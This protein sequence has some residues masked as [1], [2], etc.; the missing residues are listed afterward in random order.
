MVEEPLD[1]FQLGHAANWISPDNLDADEYLCP[2]GT[3]ARDQW[4]DIRGP[5]FFRDVFQNIEGGVG[6]WLY[7]RFR[8][9]LPKFSMNATPDCYNSQIASPGWFFFRHWAL[10]DPIQDNFLGIAQLSNRILIPPDGMTFQGTPKGEF[11]GYTYMALPMTDASDD[12]QP[13]GN[14]SMTLFVNS[15]NFKGP[16]AYYLPETWSRMSN[17]FNFP[18]IQGR[19]LDTRPISLG[20]AASIEIGNMPIITQSQSGDTYTKIPSLRFPVNGDKKTVLARDITYYSKAALFNRV[21]SW[22]KG[23]YPGFEGTFD[24]AGAVKPDLFVYPENFH[25]ESEE[26][27]FK[28]TMP[29]ATILPDNSI[30]LSWTPEAVD[31][32]GQFPQYFKDLGSQREVVEDEADVPQTLRDAPFAQRVPGAAYNAPLVGAWANPGPSAGPFSVVLNDDTRVTYYWYRFIDQP[33]FQ[34]YNYDSLQK[35]ELQGLVQAIHKNWTPN[36]TYMA[37]PTAGTLVEFDHALLVTPPNGMQVGYVPIVVR[38][39]QFIL[40]ITENFYFRIKSSNRGWC[41]ADGVGGDGLVRSCPGRGDVLVA[42]QRESDGSYRLISIRS[43]KHL[44]LDEAGDKLLSTRYQPDN[45]ATRFLLKRLRDGTYRITVKASGKHLHADESADM[46][47]STRYQP[48]DEYSHFF[49]TLD[50]PVF[51]Q[52]FETWKL[53]Q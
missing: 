17:D 49:L 44:H 52:G 23:A 36:E 18:Y 9:G 1:G 24:P 20:G 2:V 19:G 41:V 3:V 29:S 51:K 37:E 4:L 15:V 34:Q 46:L 47:L 5:T 40:G 33:A 32:Y 13:T 48:D 10:P 26:I 39:E 53:P 11:L 22:R 6:Y 27:D 12:P 7:N 16:V 35:S 43:G 31:G 14:Q 28:G 42:D 50:L 25:Q 30:G 38:Q 45:D 8:Y 21:A